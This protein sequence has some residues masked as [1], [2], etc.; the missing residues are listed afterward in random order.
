MNE[1]YKHLKQKES[2]SNLIYRMCQLFFLVHALSRIFQSKQ[3]EFY[4]I[5]YLILFN[6]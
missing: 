1:F 4:I 3:G 2:I 6:N 5:I